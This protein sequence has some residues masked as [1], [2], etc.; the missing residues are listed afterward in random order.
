MLEQDKINFLNNYNIFFRSNYFYFFIDFI[1]ITIKKYLV[2][3]LYFIFENQF[4]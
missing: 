2:Y 4:K 1:G 3:L